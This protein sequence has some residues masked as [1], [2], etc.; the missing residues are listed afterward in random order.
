MHSWIV[1]GPGNKKLICW[2]QAFLNILFWFTV[3]PA[4]HFKNLTNGRIC[5]ECPIGTY[6]SMTD[7]LS[8]RDCIEG[9]TTL[10]NGS[11]SE[12]LCGKN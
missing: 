3:C 4:G 9:A 8:C 5:E 1:V 11:I 2:H 6:N 7:Q 10:F 12:D